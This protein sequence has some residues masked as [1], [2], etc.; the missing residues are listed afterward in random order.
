MIGEAQDQPADPSKR[1]GDARFK[2]Q[3]FG[4]IHSQNI[5]PRFFG[6]LAQQKYVTRKNLL[7][8]GFTL[9]I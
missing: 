9:A 7:S 4:R 1:N 8:R 3:P 2:D 6:P 5:L